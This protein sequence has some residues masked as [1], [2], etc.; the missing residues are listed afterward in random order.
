M[1]FQGVK[2]SAAAVVLAILVSGT[3]AGNARAATNEPMI[4][5]VSAA[6]TSAA[7]GQMVGESSP[8]QPDYARR[9]AESPGMADFKGGSAGIYIGGSSVAVVLLIVLLILLV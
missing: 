6:E 3:A 1:T 2:K 7:R 8:F 4:P 9:E 5:P